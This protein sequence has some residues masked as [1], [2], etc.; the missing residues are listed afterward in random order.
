MNTKNTINAL[1]TLAV[2]G[3]MAMVVPV[4][5]APREV[6]EVMPDPDGKSPDTRKPLKVY[7]LSGQSNMCG[8][9][10]V[11][12]LK[13]LA[14]KDKRFQYLTDDKGNWTVRNDVFFGTVL[15]SERNYAWLTV[16]VRDRSGKYVGPEVGFGH[17]MGYCHDET[18][19]IIKAANGNTSLQHDWLPPT[20]RKRLNITSPVGLDPNRGWAPRNNRPAGHAYDWFIMEVHKVL[21]DLKG[22]FPDYKGQGYEIAGFCWWQGHKDKG[23]TKEKYEELLTEFIKDYRA[24]FKA[25]NAPFVVATVGF[26][27]LQPWQGVFDAQMSIS[28]PAVHPEFAG[29][30]ASVDTRGMGGGN[31]HYDS[32]GAT[33][34]R[35]GDAMGRAMVELLSKDK[36][37]KGGTNR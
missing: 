15:T 2:L 17:V 18:V 32:N 10:T 16:G 1:A 29:N 37:R 34:V 25:P 3:A 28:D 24:E 21:N 33:Y 30:V 23:L 8:M 22:H 36:G 31:Y 12:T 4:S 7:I 27:K 6:P 14:T 20:S 5:A 13:P 9:G 11:E 19:L 26:S 35:V